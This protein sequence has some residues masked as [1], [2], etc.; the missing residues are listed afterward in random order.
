[1][2]VADVVYMSTMTK[3]VARHRRRN[4]ILVGKKGTEGKFA[5]LKH[6]EK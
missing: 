2:A 6:S 5:E 1:M 4:A 3:P